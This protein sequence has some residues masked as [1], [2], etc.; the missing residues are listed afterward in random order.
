MKQGVSTYLALLILL[1]GGI[2]FIIFPILGNLEFTPQESDLIALIKTIEHDNIE[3]LFRGDSNQGVVNY[4]YA[5]IVKLL[6]SLFDTQNIAF[7]LRLPSA[8]FTIVLT[9]CLFRFD[10]VGEKLNKSFFASLIFLS[11]GFVNLLCFTAS[12]VILPAVLLILALV[13][14]YHWLRRPTKRNT[15]IFSCATAM[16]GLL[17]GGLSSIIMVVIASIFF[18]TTRIGSIKNCL[19]FASS[20]I[21]SWAILFFVV[22]IITGNKAIAFSTFDFSTDLEKLI[23]QYYNIAYVFLNYIIFAI[24]PWSIPVI[25]SLFWIL[26]NPKWIVAKFKALKLL[27]RFGIVIFLISLPSF[28]FFTK[29]SLVLLMAAMFF[30]MSLISNFLLTQLRNHPSVWRI[31]GLGCAIIVGVMSILFIILNLDVEISL[32]GYILKM[33]KCNWNGWNIVLLIAIVVSIYSLWRN[34]RDI[35]KNNRY[36]YNL[37]VLYL[38]AQT[39]YLGYISSNFILL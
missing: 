25:I 28:F 10:G 34:K 31:S 13:S 3:I 14:L 11:S 33:V 36:L 27:Q 9:A 16:A 24:F 7:I 18:A 35:M 37:I 38:L 21:L 5:Y 20:I 2:S 30:N 17:L 22:F 29:L 32:F 12:P 8:I 4:A 23:P 19:I 1:L 6:L 26:R 39:L 15:I